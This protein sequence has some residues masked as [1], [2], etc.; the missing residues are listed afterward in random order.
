MQERIEPPILISRLMTFVMAT[1][2]VVLGVLV[3]TLDKMFPLERPQV[4]FLDTQR[5]ED[6]ELIL[7]KISDAISENDM[8]MIDRMPN[9]GWSGQH[10]DTVDF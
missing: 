10:P 7:T 5:M 2:L 6:K 9:F 4:F 1:A 3:F 8:D